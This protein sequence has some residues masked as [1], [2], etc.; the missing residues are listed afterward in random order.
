MTHLYEMFFT[1]WYHFYNL[2]KVRNTDEGVLH[3]VKL[4]AKACNHTKTGTTLWGFFKLF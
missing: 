1:I 3:L 2:K 4:K